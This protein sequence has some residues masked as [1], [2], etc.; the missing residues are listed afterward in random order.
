M[1][2]RPRTFTTCS[3][4]SGRAG[5]EFFEQIASDVARVVN[6]AVL[7]DDLEITAEPHHIYEVATPRRVDACRFGEY[8][9]SH[10]VDPGP[11]KNPAHLGFL[12]EAKDVRLE[13][14]VLIGPHFPRDADARLHFIDDE[15]KLVFVGELAKRVK[16]LRTKMIVAALA[17]NRLDDEPGNVVRV[18]DEGLLDLARRPFSRRR[19]RPLHGPRAGT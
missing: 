1:R 2:P 18:V 17:L 19:R 3:L 11:G 4:R 16:K 12:A 15:Q 7:L 10:L 6:E 13:P 14:K 8:V 9:V 5:V